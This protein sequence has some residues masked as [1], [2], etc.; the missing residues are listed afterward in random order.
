MSKCASWFP[1]FVDQIILYLIDE[2]DFISFVIRAVDDEP[3]GFIVD[4]DIGVFVEYSRRIQ[5]IVYRYLFIVIFLCLPYLQ[6]ISFD[7]Y[8]EDIAFSELCAFGEF[9]TANRDFFSTEGFIDFSESCTWKNLSHISIESLSDIVRGWFYVF[10][11]LYIFLGRDVFYKHD[12][13][14]I[15]I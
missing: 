5:F 3:R 11:E 9:L 13:F 15:V 8:F 1:S 2:G 7:I 10:H 6:N 4:E 12:F 14:P